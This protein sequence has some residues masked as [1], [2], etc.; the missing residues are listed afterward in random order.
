MKQTINTVIH[1]FGV[2]FIMIGFCVY[3]GAGAMNDLDANIA[4]QV[5]PM[6][7]KGAALLFGGLFLSW[8]KV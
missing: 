4:T 8:W 7:L 3:V 6:L 1:G 2:L 5:M